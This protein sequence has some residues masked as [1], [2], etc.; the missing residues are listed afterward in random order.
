MGFTILRCT[1]WAVV[2]GSHFDL[3]RTKITIHSL[4]FQYTE[5]L[6]LRTMAG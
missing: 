5:M 3:N 6:S 1:Q 2:V 4:I